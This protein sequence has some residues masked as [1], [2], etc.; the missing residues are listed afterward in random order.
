MTEKVCD[1]YCLNCIY[2]VGKCDIALCCNYYLM[3]DKRRPCD[4]GTGCTVRVLRE[5]KRKSKK[6]RNREWLQKKKSG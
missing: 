6:E 4:P 2:Y 1:S 3:T 5:R